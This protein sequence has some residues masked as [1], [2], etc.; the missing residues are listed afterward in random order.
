MTQTC[1]ST[2][3][4][5]LLGFSIWWSANSHWDAFA[6]QSGS[7]WYQYALWVSLGRLR[8]VLRVHLPWRKP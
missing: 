8:L 2:D 4:V 1:D 5:S 6:E 3:P 7:P